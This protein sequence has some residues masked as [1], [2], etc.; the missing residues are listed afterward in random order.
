MDNILE[1]KN[2]ALGFRG[3]DCFLKALNGVDFSLERGKILGIVGE[4][5]CGKSLT[6]SSVLNLLPSNAEITTGE[7]I[8]RSSVNKDKNLLKISNKESQEIRGNLISLI[9]QDPMTS[10]NPLFTVGEQL[11]ETIIQ[12]KKL[13]RKEAIELS[14]ELL[15]KVKIPE[16]EKRLGDYPHQFSGGM[17][18]R[19]LIAMALSCN[20]ELVIADEPTTA[21][22]VTVQAQILQLIKEIQKENNTSL[23]F[24]THDLGVVAEF[25]D[26]VG[27]MYAGKIVEYSSTKE[28][29]SSSKHPYTQALIES[30][31]NKPSGELSVIGGNPPALT[32][33][34][35]GCAFHP[36]CSKKIEI[37]E[38]I[39]PEESF[40][41]NSTKVRC[42]LYSN[43]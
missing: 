3:D 8:F 38:K 17:R 40:L 11:A 14:C 32:E 10:L 6:A 20:P 2:L 28:L 31:P 33:N 9:P 22:D 34:I 37:C 18:Q 16:P 39:S 30:L 5:G 27:V 21:L 13:S 19:V 4:S 15:N 7:I 1:V 35:D 25:C 29:F 36:R 24:I 42:H 12:H 23:I 41:K 43:E 26:Y